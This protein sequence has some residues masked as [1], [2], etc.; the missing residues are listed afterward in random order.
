MLKNFEGAT[1]KLFFCP[2]CKDLLA[3]RKHYR[4]CECG[5]SGGKY[6]D[7]LN[8]EITG[9]AVGIGIHNMSLGTAIGLQPLRGW[10]RRLDAFVLPKICP[11]VCKDIRSI[12]AASSHFEDHSND[13]V[14]SEGEELDPTLF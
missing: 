14:P 12:G 10:G 9:E 11:T 1:I 4:S 2:F 5:R 13:T 8:A 6:I 3:L 7:N